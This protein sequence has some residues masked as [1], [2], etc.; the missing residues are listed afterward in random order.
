MLITDEEYNRNRK[1]DVS[2]KIE[3]RKTG[4][5]HADYV[6]WVNAQILLKENHPKLSIAFEKNADGSPVFT[7]NGFAFVQPYLTDGEERTPSIFFPVMNNTFNA[8]EHPNACEINT[9]CQRATA[10]AIATFTGLGICC[11]A[12]EDIPTQASLDNPI[13]ESPRHIHGSPPLKNGGQPSKMQGSGNVDDWR[14]YPV[15]FGKHN[16]K[17]LGELSVKSPDYIVGY[18][19]GD[20]FEFKSESFEEACRQATEAIKNGTQDQAPTEE[21][22]EVLKKNDDTGTGTMGADEEDG[23]DVPF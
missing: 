10:K 5:G 9:A 20:A 15:K 1:L 14:S 23:D 12:G 19:M 2:D 16:G 7:H 21:S 6:S 13:K 17:T 3:Q 11:F 18:L 8:I 4:W 22:V